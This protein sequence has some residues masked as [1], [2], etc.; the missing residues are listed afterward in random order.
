MLENDV[1]LLVVL[2]ER[3]TRATPIQS[4]LS[5]IQEVI[6]KTRNMPQ[7]TAT[8]EEQVLLLTILNLNAKRLS[9]NY[10]PKRKMAEKT[11]K[12]SF[13]LPMGPLSQIDIGRLTH[14]TGCVLCGSKTTKRCT[15]CLAVEYCGPGR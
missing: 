15:G 10:D 2:Y 7:I 3:G 8:L 6:T 9:A 1:P 11:F 12:L 13:L 5:W 4:T 14:N